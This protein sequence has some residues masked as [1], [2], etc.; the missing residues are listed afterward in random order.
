MNETK[1]VWISALVAMA[2]YLSGFLT[3][4]TPLPLMYA[5]AVRGR[6]SGIAASVI[7]MCAVSLFYIMLLPA[8]GPAAGWLAYVPAP[9]MGLLGSMPEGFLP[10][11]GIG[12]FAFFAAIAMTLAWGATKRLSLTAWGGYA[13]AAGAGVIVT[14][15]VVAGIVSNGSLIEGANSYILTILR[16][17]VG[18]K[19]ATGFQSAQLV[20]VADNPERVARSIIEVLPSLVF[21]Y[22]VVAVSINL[23]LGRK[24][25]GASN[26]LARVPS[27]VKF[28][29]PDWIIW[30]VIA[31]GGL[32]FANSYF[33]DYPPVRTMALNGLIAA[34]VLYFLQGAAVSIYFMQRIKFSLIRTIAYVA[35]IIF[36]QTVS[37]AFIVLGIADVWADFRLRHLKMQ[38]QQ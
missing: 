22:A 14:T 33:A 4:L 13:L 29:L 38:H 35:M 16:E 19:D 28:R 27:A 2:L 34:G 12:Y 31:S 5:A 7:S 32:F 20:F 30:A 6:R 15:L 23:V 11:F 21:V 1:A 24:F 37:I 25:M 26:A 3:I 9:G 8:K 18:A 17:V 36:L 10:V